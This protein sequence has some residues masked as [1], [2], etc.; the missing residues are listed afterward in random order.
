MPR[1]TANL[2][3]DGQKG[4]CINHNGNHE[5]LLW[6]PLENGARVGEQ[7]IGLR[8]MY[9]E[10][11]CFVINENTN[12]SIIKDVCKWGVHIIYTFNSL[13]AFLA[14]TLEEFATAG[15]DLKSCE[16][17]W[18]K[19]TFQIRAILWKL[20]CKCN[21]GWNKPFWIEPNWIQIASCVLETK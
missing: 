14:V 11:K 5:L 12:F 8:S 2:H 18:E 21:Q 15:Y 20:I 19:Y 13:N 3:Y 4:P 16:T 9:K 1:I 7:A 10:K 6:T 17:F